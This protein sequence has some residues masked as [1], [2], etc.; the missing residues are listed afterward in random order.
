L[1]LTVTTVPPPE[2]PEVGLTLVTDAV[3]AADS[4]KRSL[5]D[6]ADVPV[7]L[8]TVASMVPAALGGTTAD[9]SVSL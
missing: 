2:V 8:V 6:R 4:V 9:R 7:K 3:E 1:P 5:L